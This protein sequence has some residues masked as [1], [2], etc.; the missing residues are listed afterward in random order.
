VF[1]RDEQ[2]GTATLEVLVLSFYA[3]VRMEK[4]TRICFAVEPYPTLS[5]KYN[6]EYET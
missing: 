5:K 2:I 4:H 6:E 3:I 1:Y